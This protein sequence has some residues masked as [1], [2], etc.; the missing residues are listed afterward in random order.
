MKYQYYI[1]NAKTEER[2]PVE[3]VPATIQDYKVTKEDGWQSNWLTPAMQKPG[4]DNYAIKIVETNELV[5]LASYRD[6]PEGIIVYIQY[7]EAS[8]TNNPVLTPDR[9]HLGIGAALIAYGVQLSLDKGYDGSVYFKAKTSE[10]LKH[11]I[12]NYGAFQYTRAD[13]FMLMLLPEEGLPLLNTYLV[14]ED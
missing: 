14:E 2:V 3:F 7:A 8:R 11:Y 9:E 12:Q 4:L 10:L 6:I 1:T 5:G 13:P